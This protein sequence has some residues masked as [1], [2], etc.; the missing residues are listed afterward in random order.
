MPAEQGFSEV[1]HTADL[2]LKIDGQT[3]SELFV[4]AAKGTAWLTRC[5]HSPDSRPEQHELTLQSPD[6]ESLLVSWL[7]ELLYL[8]FER[9]LLPEAYKL[10]ELTPFSLRATVSGV[11]PCKARREVKAATFHDLVVSETPSG[12][13]AVV[14]F[15]I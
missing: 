4:H 12:Y 2:A 15:D 1:A 11:T 3:I 6:I 5:D 10:H 13:Q 7:N 14:V 9:H 8:I